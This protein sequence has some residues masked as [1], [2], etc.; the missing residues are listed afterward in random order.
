M[1]SVARSIPLR[2]LLLTTTSL[3]FIPQRSLAF[4]ISAGGGA[5]EEG[6]DRSR[7]AAIVHM[8]FPN[9][10]ISRAYM[11]GRT[12]GPVTETD[13]ILTVA[14]RYDIF[15]AK[16]LGSVVGVSAMAEKTSIKY[17]DYPQE[18]TSYTSTNAG[19]LLGLHYDL[20]TGRTL[21]VAASWEGHVFPAGGA[22]IFLVTARKQI[23]GMTA[24]VTF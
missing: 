10:Y 20:W 16:S 2:I 12:F 22:V 7:P 1:A 6:D 18:N 4:E 17:D 14:K 23:L 11:W 15:G 21:K 13:G 24:G 8:S 5:L 3:A 9:N 19:L